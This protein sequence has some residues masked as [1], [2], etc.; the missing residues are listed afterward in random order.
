MT[1]YVLMLLINWVSKFYTFPTLLD[2]Q[3]SMVIKGKE[4]STI[5]ANGNNKQNIKIDE[6]NTF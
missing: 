1:I 3:S 5:L 4:Y 6:R 2:K